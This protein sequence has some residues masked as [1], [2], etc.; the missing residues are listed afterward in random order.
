MATK[1]KHQQPPSSSSHTDIQDLLEKLFEKLLHKDIL[2]PPKP[3]YQGKNIQDHILSVNHYLQTSKINDSDSKIAVLI[4][5][6]DDDVQILLFSQAN[7]ESHSED[8]DWICNTLLELFNEK[9][10]PV[11]PLHNLLQIKQTSEQTLKKY[12]AALRIAAFKTMKQ[13]PQN[14][15]EGY[16]LTAFLKG[17]TNRALAKAI[18]TLKPQSVEEALRLAEQEEKCLSGE[19]PHMVRGMQKDEI[20]IEK[21]DLRLILNQLSVLRKQVNYLIECM[22]QKNQPIPRT[23]NPQRPQLNTNQTIHGSKQLK[24]R[25]EQRPFRLPTK[26]FRCE[27]DGHIARNCNAKLHCSLCQGDHLS[28]DCRRRTFQVR[29]IH[30]TTDGGQSSASDEEEMHKEETDK[31]STA[32]NIECFTLRKECRQKTTTKHSTKQRRS[33]LSSEEK[34]AVMWT[35]YI[36]G[37]GKKP[38]YENAPTV[39]STSRKE[40]ARNKPLV[41][42]FCEGLQTKLFLDSG[43]EVNVIDAKFFKELQAYANNK[44]QFKPQQGTIS[45]ANGTKMKTLG[46]AALRIGIGSTAATIHFTVAMDLFPKIIIGIRGMKTLNIQ[47]DPA[48]D[49]AITCHT[50]V[51]FISSVYPQSVWSE[52]EKRSAL[53]ARNG[54]QC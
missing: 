51:P 16:L 25:M 43:A 6:L 15:R 23:H 12:V 42:G 38:K 11:S 54:P 52:N 4:N 37:R 2:S 19:N 30:H 49:R 17:I 40:N 34:D 10:S 36:E 20:S 47:L 46:L 35:A 39:I 53:G 41:T 14:I 44:I 50:S 9:S 18:A 31:E 29:R 7:Y 21:N 13:V 27:Q 22:N 3:F 33:N 48:N 5:S 45:C 28:K 26:C 24:T 1:R 32:S 8:Y